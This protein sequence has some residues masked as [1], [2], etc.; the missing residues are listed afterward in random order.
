MKR[1]LVLLLAVLMLTGCSD[2]GNI[3][4]VELDTGTSV[5][6]TEKEIEDAM[7]LVLR[8]FEKGF[9]ACTMT[10]LWYDEAASTKEAASWARQYGAE[11]AIILYSNFWV[12]ASGRNPSLNQGSLYNNWSWIL[13]RSGGKWELKDWGY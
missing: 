1:M 5:L 11:E 6:Y 8:Q 3:D 10:K 4:Y 7:D 12:D 2:H 9:E 13:V